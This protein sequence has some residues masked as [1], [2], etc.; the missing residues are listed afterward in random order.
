MVFEEEED[1]EDNL[2]D[3]RVGHRRSS[4]QD[5]LITQQKVMT[6]FSPVL[7]LLGI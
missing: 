6:D 7:A 1:F 5:V 4:N 3:R 2:D